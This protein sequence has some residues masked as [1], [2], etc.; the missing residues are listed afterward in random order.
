MP[1]YGFDEFYCITQLAAFNLVKGKFFQ[2]PFLFFEYRRQ[3]RFISRQDSRGGSLKKLSLA[4]LAKL[5]W[6]RYR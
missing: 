5:S 3:A 6:L 2:L 1:V 4:G